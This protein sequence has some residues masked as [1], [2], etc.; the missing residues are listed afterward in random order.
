MKGGILLFLALQ[1]YCK[2]LGYKVDCTH[3]LHE[4]VMADVFLSRNL[5][6]VKLKLPIK[7]QCLALIHEIGHIKAYKKYNRRDERSA[8]AEGWSFI[9][10][11]KI[12]FVTLKEWCEFNSYSIKQEIKERK[13]VIHN[14]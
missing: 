12:N 3:D 7:K 2:Y 9:S 13:E 5:I 10:V 14:D 4:N 11:N 1:D 6:R 8:V